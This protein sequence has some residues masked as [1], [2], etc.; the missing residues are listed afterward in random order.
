VA[1]VLVVPLARAAGAFAAGDAGSTADRLGRA[2]AALAAGGWRPTKDLAHLWFLY[3]LLYYYAAAGRG[4][5]RRAAG[6]RPGADR[7]RHDRA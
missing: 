5:H 3:Y 1:W 4:R 2:W 7:A 6:E